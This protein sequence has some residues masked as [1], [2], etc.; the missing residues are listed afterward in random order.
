MAL[1]G[2]QYV[3]GAGVCGACTILASRNAV[4]SC[5]VPL[6]GIEGRDRLTIEGLALNEFRQP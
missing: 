5:Q 1:T 4:R 2:T 6:K 3:C